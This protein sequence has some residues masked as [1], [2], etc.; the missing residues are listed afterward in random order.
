MRKYVLSCVVLVLPLVAVAQEQVVTPTRSV[1]IRVSPPSPWLLGFPGWKVG[2]TRQSEQY[3]LLR[4]LKIRAFSS[5]QTWAEVELQDSVDNPKKGWVYW[6]ES[7]HENQNFAIRKL[8]AD[9]LGTEANP[10]KSEPHKQRTTTEK[11][12]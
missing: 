4:T 1:S 10:P 2:Q 11:G 9:P 12:S 7:L 5:T 8:E 6:G 3:T